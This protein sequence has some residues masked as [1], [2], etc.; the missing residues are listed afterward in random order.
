VGVLLDS[1]RDLLRL[2]AA[3]LVPESVQLSGAGHAE[4]LAIVGEALATRP[5]QMQ[6]QF[7]LFLHVLRWAP[8]ARYGRRLDRLAP[9]QQDA[10]LRWFQDCPVQL[11]RSGFWGVRTLVMMGYYTRPDVGAAIGYHPSGDGNA[12][13]H[14]RTRR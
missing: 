5:A 6:R 14:A 2:L 13:L 3:R 10:V 4:M 7:S 1:Q 12:V 11:V 9:Q 8:V